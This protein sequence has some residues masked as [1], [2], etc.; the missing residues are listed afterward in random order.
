MVNHQRRKGSIN[1]ILIV[2]LYIFST[3]YIL[4]HLCCKAILSLRECMQHPEELYIDRHFITSFDWKLIIE[5]IQACL[6]LFLS[7]FLVFNFQ[8]AI[9]EN[10]PDRISFLT[11]SLI[12]LYFEKSFSDY[13]WDGEGMYRKNIYSLLNRT[14]RPQFVTCQRKEYIKDLGI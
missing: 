7:F 1:C 4:H 5:S 3:Q 12:M 10:G 14:F 2:S 11:I 8:L 9:F 13:L 6:P